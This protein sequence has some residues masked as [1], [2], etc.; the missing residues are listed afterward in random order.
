MDE[1]SSS[2]RQRNAYLRWA[3]LTVP[4]VLILGWVSGRIGDS[5]YG[6]IWFARLDKPAIMPPGWV[7]GFT[8]SILYIMMA[9]ALAFILEARGAKGR[10]IAIALFVIQ[11]ALNLAWSPVF[12][13]LHKIMLAFGLIVAILLWAG[14]T[15]ILFWH[16]RRIA[17]LLM[18][19]YLAWLL[20]AGY[21]NWQIHLMN[22][23]GPA[24]VP[25]TGDTQIVVQ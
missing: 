6:N 13:A 20:F 17:A 25:S 19:P 16:I 4:P 10:G 5:G 18:I 3:V 8:W 2:R 23:W 21:L 14:I 12:F 11:F 24:L 1:T 22:P 15:T 7:F 9:A